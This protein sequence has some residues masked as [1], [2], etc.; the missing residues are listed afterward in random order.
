MTVAGMVPLCQVDDMLRRVARPL[1]G[2]GFTE[3][4]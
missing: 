4:G 2:A 3:T 1:R